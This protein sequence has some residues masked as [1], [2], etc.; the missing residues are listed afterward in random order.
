MLAILPFSF[1]LYVTGQTGRSMAA[2]MNLRALC[3]NHLAGRYELEI[4]DAVEQPD[5]AEQQGILAT[6]ASHDA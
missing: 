1:R 4:V 6:V 3:D 2:V 5:L